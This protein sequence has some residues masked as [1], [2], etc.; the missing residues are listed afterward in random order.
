MVLIMKLKS[1]LAIVGFFI[2][3]IISLFLLANYNVINY[4][5]IHNSSINSTIDPTPSTIVTINPN[6]S[7]DYPPNDFVINHMNWSSYPN[8][9]TG[10]VYTVYIAGPNEVIPY[11]FIEVQICTEITG[12]EDRSVIIEQLNG[13]AREAKM[14]Y[15]PNSSINIIG[16]KGGIARWFASIL[17]NEDQI[18]N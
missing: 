12:T 7:F 6:N 11:K 18:N 14:I 2:I 10:Y 1:I 5:N 8:L 17:P 16:T 4:F 13:I 9:T 15:G 3:V